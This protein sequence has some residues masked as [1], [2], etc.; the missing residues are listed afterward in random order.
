M[1]GARLIQA[2]G[3]DNKSA[4]DIAASLDNALEELHRLQR[5]LEPRNATTSAE[6]SL[7]G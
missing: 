4:A 5:S 3:V 1:A 2:D 6:G 7:P